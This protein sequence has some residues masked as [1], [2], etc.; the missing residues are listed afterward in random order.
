VAVAIF[1][2]QQQQQ[3]LS[4]ALAGKQLNNPARF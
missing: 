1:P 3:Q 2:P 4:S